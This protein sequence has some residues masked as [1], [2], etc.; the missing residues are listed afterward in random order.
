VLLSPRYRTSTKHKH[1]TYTF[2]INPYYWDYTLVKQ[3]LFTFHVRNYSIWW[4]VSGLTPSINKVTS[5]IW[6]S[7][8]TSFLS[9]KKTP[10]L[11][12]EFTSYSLVCIIRNPQKFPPLSWPQTK[13]MLNHIAHHDIAYWVSTWVVLCDDRNRIIWPAYYI[14]YYE[15]IICPW[16]TSI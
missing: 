1:V 7:D 14:L 9:W 3:C 16:N 10:S 5:L 15:I 13:S 4:H 2:V 11:E 6:I 12:K 8:S